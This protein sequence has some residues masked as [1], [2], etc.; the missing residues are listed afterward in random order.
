[1]TPLDFVLAE[2]ASLDAARDALPSHSHISGLF[3]LTVYRLEEDAA[4]MRRV[5]LKN[6]AC[7][8]SSLPQEKSSDGSVSAQ[9]LLPRQNRY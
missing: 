7:I 1:M 4:A 9:Q 6:V 8:A 3:S 2:I 5:A